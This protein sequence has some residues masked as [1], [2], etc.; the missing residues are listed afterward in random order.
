VG[1]SAHTL[2]YGKT[3]EETDVCLERTAAHAAAGKREDFGG[4]STGNR[5]LEEGRNDKGIRKKGGVGGSAQGGGHRVAFKEGE[6]DEEV[7]GGGKRVR[8]GDVCRRGQERVVE[9]RARKSR[10][11]MEATHLEEEASA[12]DVT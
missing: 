12:W 4:G 10:A 6:A 11:L 2:K 7:Q 8:E 9:S 5:R 3:R 1:C